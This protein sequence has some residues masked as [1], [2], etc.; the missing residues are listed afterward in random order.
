MSSSTVLPAGAA[1]LL[2]LFETD[3]QGI[4]FP[5]VDA[6]RLQQEVERCRTQAVAV[7]ELAANL[8]AAREELASYQAGL[9]A[10]GKKAIAYA[11]VYAA[12]NPELRSKLEAMGGDKRRGPRSTKRDEQGRP[13]GKRAKKTAAASDKGMTAAQAKGPAGTVAG[14]NT[15]VQAERGATTAGPAAGPAAGGVAVVEAP[16]VLQATG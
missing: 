15:V 4:A 7:D 1:E 9:K 10:L 5:D 11:K 14:P 16:V 2:Q 3:L 6:S 13:R 12:D 8:A